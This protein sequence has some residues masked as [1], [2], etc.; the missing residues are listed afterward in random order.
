M[1]MGDPMPYSPRGLH[2]FNFD[3]CLPQFLPR[4][5]MLVRYMLSSCVRPSVFLSVTSR[6]FTKTS[7]GFSA[8]AELLDRPHDAPDRWLMWSSG[9]R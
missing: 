2:P 4:D 3:Y 5:A 8:V 9:N 6:Y 7:R 1:G